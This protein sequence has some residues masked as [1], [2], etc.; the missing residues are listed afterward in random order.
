MALVLNVY[1]R[2]DILALRFRSV[3]LRMGLFKKKTR[4]LQLIQIP[5]HIHHYKNIYFKNHFRK[6]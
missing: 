5:A 3:G 1:I 4:W 2:E 6:H